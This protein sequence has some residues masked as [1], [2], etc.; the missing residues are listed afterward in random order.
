MPTLHTRPRRRLLT[1]GCTF[2]VAAALASTVPSATAQSAPAPHWGN[3]KWSGGQ[4]TANIRAFWLVD[5][6][7]DRTAQALIKIAVDAWNGA[8]DVAPELPFIAIYKDD[9]NAG[10]CFVNRTPGYS[11]ASACM[12][13][14]NIHGVKSI[15][16]RNADSSGHLVGAAFAISDGLDVKESLTAVCHGLGHVMGLDDSDNEA[17]C[18]FPTSNPDEAKW[19]DNDADVEAILGLYDHDENAA[20]TTTSAPT[21]TTVAPTTTTVAPTTT[22]VEPTTT[23]TLEPTT[24]TSTTLIDCSSVPLPVGCPL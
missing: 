10:R 24:T 20:T 17:S 5:R 21:T 14:N 23:T 19:Y 8:R 22:T 6:T 4:E 13:P 7:G 15:A 2:V 12:F 3:Y 1:L 16:A 18:M 9:A 11:V